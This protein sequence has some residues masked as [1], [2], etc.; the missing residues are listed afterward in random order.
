M[1]NNS[2][3]FRRA[4]DRYILDDDL[5]ENANS[6]LALYNRGDI[7]F[8]TT[9]KL[10]QDIHHNIH[11]DLLSDIDESALAATGLFC[12]CH[13]NGNNFIV[14][15]TPI[16]GGGNTIKSEQLFQCVQNRLP[17]SENYYYTPTGKASDCVYVAPESMTIACVQMLSGNLDS[18]GD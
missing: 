7:T 12:K 11:F 4:I 3:R 8:E 18:C 1:T 17:G 9:L 6:I 2:E 14:D 13:K 5:K 10:L 16:A 15:S